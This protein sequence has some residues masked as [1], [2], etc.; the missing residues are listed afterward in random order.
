MVRN[1]KKAVKKVADIYGPFRIGRGVEKDIFIAI[2]MYKKAA[3]IKN[4]DAAKELK[5]LKIFSLKI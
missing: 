2:E 5:W 1:D 3:N 4:P